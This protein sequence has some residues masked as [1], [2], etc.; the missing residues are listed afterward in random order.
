MA[1][2]KNNHPK[3]NKTPENSIVKIMIMENNDDN[4]KKK[5]KKGQHPRRDSNPRPLD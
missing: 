4:I 1:S 2:G 3:Q 5:E